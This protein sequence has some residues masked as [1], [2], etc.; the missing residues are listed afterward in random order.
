MSTAN[1]IQIKAIAYGF[2]GCYVVF[3]CHDG[4]GRIY[5]FAWPES[6]SILAGADPAY[7]A[8]EEV[9]EIPEEMT[10]IDDVSVSLED[11]VAMSEEFYP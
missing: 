8:G 11:A 1:I 4:P 9:G 3:E 6:M 10:T 7:F 2:G 5:Y